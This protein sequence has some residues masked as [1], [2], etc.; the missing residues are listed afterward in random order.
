MFGSSPLMCGLMRTDTAG[1]EPSEA[2]RQGLGRDWRGQRSQRAAFDC[3]VL[4]FNERRGSGVGLE[5]RLCS[6]LVG[7]SLCCGTT[8][9]P[10]V[11]HGGPALRMA[12]PRHPWHTKQAPASQREAGLE[13]LG[14]PALLPCLSLAPS[15]CCLTMVLT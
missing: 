2:Q 7:F 15:Y 14:H 8:E 1:A 10:G 4:S 12:L 13:A 3:S 5:L 9:S 11:S 6:E